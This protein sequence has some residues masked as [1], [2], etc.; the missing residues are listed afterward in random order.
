MTSRIAPSDMSDYSITAQRLDEI[1]A[2][3]MYP[4]YDYDDRGNRGD[5]EFNI[6][7]QNTQLNKQL[8]FLFPFFG[9]GLNYTWVC[10]LMISE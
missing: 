9:F 7:A 6:N 4:Y 1:R 5:L 10:S 3:L 2:Y 8:T